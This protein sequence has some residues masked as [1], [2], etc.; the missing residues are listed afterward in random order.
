MDAP[1]FNGSDERELGGPPPKSVRQVFW[2]TFEYAR[3]RGQLAEFFEIY[4]PLTNPE[5]RQLVAEAHQRLQDAG[6]LVKKD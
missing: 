6:V 3:R 5:F 4:E 2:Q 1:S